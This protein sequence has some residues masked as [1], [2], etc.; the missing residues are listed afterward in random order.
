M[1]R[2]EV[3][4]ELLET[5]VRF[6]LW[7]RMKRMLESMSMEELGQYIRTGTWPERPDPPPGASRLDK[8]D[9]QSL[10]KEWREAQ[11]A[12]GWP[13]DRQLDDMDTGPTRAAEQTV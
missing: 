2:I 13:N 7:V 10:L 5:E 8:M 11:E 9:R 12:L 6:R 4:V 3:L 1:S